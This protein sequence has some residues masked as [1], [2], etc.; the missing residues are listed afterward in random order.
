MAEMSRLAYSPYETDD[1]ELKQAL[2]NADFELVRIFDCKGTQAFLAKRNSTK[3][4]VLAFRG[5]QPRKWD[6]IKTDIEIRF[7][8]DEKGAKIH[9]GF[10]KAFN[11]VEQDV[12]EMIKEL[13]DHS[14]Y[15]TGHSLGGALALIATRALDLDN[16]AACY[17]FG[18]PKVGN[19]EFG[20]NIKTPI[21]RVI[22]AY[23]I[24]PFLPPSGLIELLS[25]LPYKG[26]K[27]VFVNLRGFQHHGDVRYIDPDE[28]NI[29]VIENYSEM[30]RFFGLW[31]NR[32]KGIECHSIKKYCEK[33]GQWALKR[34]GA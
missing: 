15:I 23:D 14:I 16:L 13:T 17:T 19:E 29:K 32:S 21:Y 20:E 11:C 33:L 2:S 22:N 24:V 5:T 27:N 1:T 6:D 4:A 10:Y 8:H 3:M 30:F 28:K 12:R 25:L 26:L 31:S 9:I 18:G 34:F 7:Y